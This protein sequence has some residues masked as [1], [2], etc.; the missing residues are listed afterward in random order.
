[1]NKLIG[2]HFFILYLIKFLNILIRIKYNKN[3]IKYNKL[4]A[5]KIIGK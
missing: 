3:R 1:M 4:N 2:I 5:E